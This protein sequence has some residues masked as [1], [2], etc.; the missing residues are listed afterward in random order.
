MAQENLIRLAPKPPSADPGPQAKVRP[1]AE[2]AALVAQHQA[3][4]RKVALCHGCFDLL[5]VG[6]I[7]HLEQAKALADVLLVTLTPDRFVDKGPHRPAFP[8]GLRAE[9]LAALA[10]VDLVGINQW[11]TAEE[12]LRLLRPDFYVK[13]SEYKGIVDDRTGK[14]GRELEVVEEIGAT[15][16]FTEDIVFSSSNLINR[17]F[18]NL[19]SEVNNF[20]TDFRQRHGL[21]DILA[22]LDAMASLK[23]L[24]VGDA[25]L[26]DYHYCEL[27]GRSSKDP[28]L[29]LRFHHNEMMAGGALAVANHVANFAGQVDL[30]TVLGERDS[31]EEFIRSSLHPNV[32]PQFLVRPG[33]PT[34]IK[35]R[36]IDRYSL[37]K[38]LEVYI[39]E[40]GEPESSQ[41]RPICD[42]L[43]AELG[44]YD[45]VIA[46]DFGH[47]AITREMVDTLT[48]YAPF[49]A[50]NTQANAGNRGFHT[51]GRYR[52]CHYACLAE[53]EMRLEMRDAGGPLRPMLEI[54]GR[55]LGCQQMVVTRGS[56]G[57]LMR[58]GRG[59]MREVPAFSYKIVDR[60][61][62]GDAFLS[63]SSLAAALKADQEMLGLIGNVAGSMAVEIVGNKSALNRQG[64]EKFL[65]ALLK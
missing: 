27:I 43:Q 13:G 34:L 60:V 62:A 6:H 29:A 38:L 10:C 35:R 24:V 26:D 45:L 20:L 61:G 63:V 18:N 55:R 50:V 42:R 32:N 5:H 28:V 21:A 51:I 40:A 25:I 12:T 33:A 49:L 1:L 48:D 8:E 9:S 58:D 11:P 59:L 56:K 17:Y 30:L 54:T 22:C 53:H 41:T 15:L 47:G 31:H 46:S 39:M 57:C 3:A 19:P 64:M 65:T 2:L 4:G 52:Q 16:A 36:F 44:G 14:I 7:R 37:S 23:V